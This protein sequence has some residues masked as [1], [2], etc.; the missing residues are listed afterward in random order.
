MLII[1]DMKYSNHYSINLGVN[2]NDKYISYQ[3]FK[4]DFINFNYSINII[5]E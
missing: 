2:S 1:L 4:G 3:V 5:V